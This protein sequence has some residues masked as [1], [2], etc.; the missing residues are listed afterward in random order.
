MHVADGVQRDVL[1]RIPAAAAQKRA[2][3]DGHSRGVKL[4]D[5]A[6]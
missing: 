6:I 2:E 3:Q 1:T 4:R 5:E